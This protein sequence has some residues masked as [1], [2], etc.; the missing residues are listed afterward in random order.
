MSPLINSGSVLCAL[1]RSPLLR[2]R[3]EAAKVDAMVFLDTLALH[4]CKYVC[5]YVL[6][7]YVWTPVNKEHRDDTYTVRSKSILALRNSSICFF[8]GPYCMRRIKS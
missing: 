2:A 1:E 6:C 8:Q 7:I 4:I 5:M 3:M